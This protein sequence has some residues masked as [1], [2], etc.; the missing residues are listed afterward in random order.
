MTVA[1]EMLLPPSAMPWGRSVEDRIADTD[2]RIG[3]Q[4]SVD[5]GDAA[6]TRAAADSISERL[7]ELEKVMGISRYELAPFS[8][9]YSGVPLG[10]DPII[11]YTPTWN[12]NVP[13]TVETISAILQLEL[14]DGSSGIGPRLNNGIFRVGSSMFISQLS[15]Y[16]AS[17]LPYPRS[18]MATVPAE[19]P[20]QVSAGFRSANLTGG[21]LSGTGMLTLVMYGR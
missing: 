8:V 21:T 20:L 7:G 4:F 10:G 19:H 13:S 2:A 18:M 14:S 5:N 1:P 16:D 12:I 17:V 15:N 9:P 6:S 11:V 3:Y